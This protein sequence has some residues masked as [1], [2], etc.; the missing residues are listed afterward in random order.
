MTSLKM[1][2][3]W[4]SFYSLG[5]TKEFSKEL[6]DCFYGSRGLGGK[7]AVCYAVCDYFYRTERF[8]EELGI[9]KKVSWDFKSSM[10]WT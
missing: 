3:A 5:V 2:A 6:G 8:F 9:F 7:L 10:G 1:S 4:G